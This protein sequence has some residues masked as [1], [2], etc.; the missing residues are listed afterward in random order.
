MHICCFGTLSLRFYLRLS[1]CT[2][3]YILQN[4]SLDLHAARP[5]QSG[6]DDSTRNT[7]QVDAG[8]A[9][10]DEAPVTM[11]TLQTNF[12]VI[13]CVSSHVQ[14]WSAR[15]RAAHTETRTRVYHETRT[16]ES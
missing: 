7:P 1:A 9:R 12:T 16:S 8:T 14:N 6:M 10:H 2:R 3:C 4:S 11:A 5:C 13:V 15:T